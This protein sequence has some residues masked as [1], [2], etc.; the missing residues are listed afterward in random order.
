MNLVCNGWV[1]KP[2]LGD[3]GV[4]AGWSIVHATVSLVNGE[5]GCTECCNR[6]IFVVQDGIEFPHFICSPG[7]SLKQRPLAGSTSGEIE[8]WCCRD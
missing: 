6:P 7:C 8:V 3:D 1:V 5:N 2:E 4:Q